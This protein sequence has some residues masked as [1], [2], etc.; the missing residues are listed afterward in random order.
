ME[1]CYFDFEGPIID[2]FYSTRIIE[3]EKCAAFVP[4][5]EQVP[6]DQACVVKVVLRAVSEDGLLS[7]AAEKQATW[8]AE[9]SV[10]ET[11]QRFGTKSCRV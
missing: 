1:V 5:P 10:E 11:A 4:H 6:R 7:E 2:P 8:D 9:L 3:V